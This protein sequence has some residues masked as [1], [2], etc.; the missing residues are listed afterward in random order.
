MIVYSPQCF[1]FGVHINQTMLDVAVLLSFGLAC[2]LLAGAIAVKL[3]V[4]TTVRRLAIGK[5]LAP[6]DDSIR[7]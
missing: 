4:V 3:I 5:I 6:T 7:R 2:P 1:L